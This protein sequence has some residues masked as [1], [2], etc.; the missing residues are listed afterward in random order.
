MSGR[1]GGARVAWAVAAAVLLPAVPACAQ[2]LGAY[3][4]KA[5]AREAAGPAPPRLG[6]ARSSEQAGFG[7]VRPLKIFLG[8]DPTGLVEKIHWTGW[9]DGQAIGSGEAEY[10]WPG[11]A[12]ADNGI[13]PGA[14]VVAFHLGTCRGHLSY[15]AVEWYFP[16]DGQVFDP[17][18]YIDTCT[19]AVLGIPNVVSCP[20]VRLADGAG[21]ATFVNVSAMSCETASRL[22]AEA[23]AARYLSTGG[24]FI[25]S[26][27]RCGT[28]GA[29][30]P[31]SAGFSCQKGPLE[32]SYVAEPLARTLRMRQLVCLRGSWLMAC[33]SS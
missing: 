8:G 5:A 27:F 20:D 29:K 11:T 16:K 14:R 19:G 18:E 13:V 31:G 9:G 15:N 2:A 32:F 26:G 4:P 22:I 24:R 7:R 1:R 28:E 10:D 3:P 30:G 23:P 6:R 33:R 25:Q 17:H 21:T 12:V